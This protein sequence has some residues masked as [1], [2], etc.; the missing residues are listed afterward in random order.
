MASA[1]DY[2]AMGKNRRILLWRTKMTVDTKGVSMTDT[3]PAVIVA[4]G[5]YF[6]RETEE[7][8]VLTKRVVRQGKVDVGTPTVVEPVKK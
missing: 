6:G 8:T 5:P 2:Q 4:A 3:L 7:A 1:Y